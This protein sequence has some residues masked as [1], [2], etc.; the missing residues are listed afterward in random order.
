MIYRALSLKVEERWIGALLHMRVR[1]L[2]VLRRRL[3]PFASTR[4]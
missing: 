4:E 1:A 2:F 3:P